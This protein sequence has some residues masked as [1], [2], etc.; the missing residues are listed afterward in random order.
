[1]KLKSVTITLIV[2]LVVHGSLSSIATKVHYIEDTTKFIQLGPHPI[3][4]VN[5]VNGDKDLLVSSKN[6][7]KNEI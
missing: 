7:S 4:E 2:A 5:Y 3:M 6:R 1:M